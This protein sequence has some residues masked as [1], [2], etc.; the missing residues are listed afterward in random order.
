MDVV[1]PLKV[2]PFSPIATAWENNLTELK[3]TIF[4]EELKI[5]RI[6]RNP[7]EFYG[8]LRLTYVYTLLSPD[9]SPEADECSPNLPHPMYF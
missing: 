2:N 3:C 9:P 4:F 6:F 5:A 7:I 8:T 1:G